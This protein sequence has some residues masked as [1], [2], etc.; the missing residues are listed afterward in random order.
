M[1]M[2]A[3]RAH[4]R[5]CRPQVRKPKPVVDLDLR[6][7]PIAR[8]AEVRTRL[9]PAETYLAK[10]AERDGIVLVEDVILAFQ[11][12]RGA[13]QFLERIRSKP[14]DPLELMVAGQRSEEHTSELQS[15]AYL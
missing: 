6:E 8:Q 5:I 11:K 2:V 10:L 12:V 14:D 1:P 7:P 9:L 3:F 15:L 4:I 13:I